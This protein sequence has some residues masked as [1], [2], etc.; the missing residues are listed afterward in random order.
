MEP[1]SKTSRDGGASLY[2]Y[3]DISARRKSLL[4]SILVLTTPLQYMVFDRNAVMDTEN[5][6]HLPQVHVPV[7]GKGFQL[8]LVSS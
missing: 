6:N 3:S 4:A 2:D 8:S 1:A 7:F 5:P